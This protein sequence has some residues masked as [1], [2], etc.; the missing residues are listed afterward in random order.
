MPKKVQQ[1]E[2]PVLDMTMPE[3]KATDM[4]GFFRDHK[5][6]DQDVTGFS[7]GALFTGDSI[8]WMKTINDES[9]DMVFADPPYNIKKADW[10]DFGSQERYIEWSMR[11]IEQASR[12]LKPTGSLYVCGFSEI[13]ADL[14]HPSMRYFSS[15][16]W[17]VWFYRNKANLGKDW[18][19]S[20]E[21]ILHLRKK[22][23]GHINYDDVRIPYGKHTLKYPDHPQ[24]DSSQYGRKGSHWTPNPLGAKPKDVVEIPTTCNGM[25]EKTPHP[26]QKPEELLRKLILASSSEGDLVLDPFSGSGTTAVVASQLHRQWLACD[27]NPEYNQWATQRLDSI[28]HA[29][30][31]EQW[32]AFDRDNYERRRSIR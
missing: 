23:F 2:H 22:D 5:L 18:G 27:E 21:S 20:H 15:C 16:R 1:T 17:L 24:A 6:P 25:N 31:V 32:M 10:D 4:S 13:L 14:K 11:W 26:T 19:R 7:D 3:R 8:E 9:I 28:D 30:T 12:I 29:R